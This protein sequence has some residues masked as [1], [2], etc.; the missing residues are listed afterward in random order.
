MIKLFIAFLLADTALFQLIGY[1]DAF[2]M[3]AHHMD[4]LVLMTQQ[5]LLA[6]L[7]FYAVG[8]DNLIVKTIAFE[9]TLTEA[10]DIGQY[11]YFD[12]GFTFISTSLNL[13]LFVPWL[14]YAI[15][16]RYDA[17]C[18][19]PGID[20][21]YLVSK[22]PDNIWTFLPSL[23]TGT[24]GYSVLINGTKYGYCN[25]EVKVRDYYHPD[26][27]YRYISASGIEYSDNILNYLQQKQGTK[28]KPW[29]NCITVHL[30]IKFMNWKVGHV[31]K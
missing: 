4:T 27:Q 21:V 17:E 5:L 7:L 3:E 30:K 1:H 14:I 20:R 6:A 9:F 10:W 26:N 24:S 11:L 31:Y 22:K 25:G 13:A 16:R 19:S 23:F 12:D 15:F 28:W 2:N 29:D 8:Y 18:E